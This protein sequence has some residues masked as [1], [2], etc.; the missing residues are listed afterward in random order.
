MS[1]NHR[2]L[3]TDDFF[4]GGVQTDEPE[5]L[6]SLE[7]SSDSELSLLETSLEIEDNSILSF[8]LDAFGAHLE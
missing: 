4:L 3:E 7:Y 2:D 6:R 1:L 5:L 8:V